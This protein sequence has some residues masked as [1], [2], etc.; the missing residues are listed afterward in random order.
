MSELEVRGMGRSITYKRDIIPKYF[1]VK[2][3]EG[4][5]ALGSVGNLYVPPQFVHFINGT[6]DTFTV[7]VTTGPYTG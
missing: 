2:N 6:P 3:K 1:L 7:H 5:K 4:F